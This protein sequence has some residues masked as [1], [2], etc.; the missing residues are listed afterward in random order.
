MLSMKHPHRTSDTLA[1]PLPPPNP[2]NKC[3]FHAAGFVPWNP[4][5]PVS[6]LLFRVP[7]APAPD[8]FGCHDRRSVTF[9]L[10]KFLL[11]LLLLT[12]AATALAADTVERW[13]TY[14]IALRGPA[15]GNP[16]MD[17]HLAAR[18]RLGNHIVD[19]AGFY[20]GDGD[21][22]IR[23]MPGETGQWT[24]ATSSNLPVLDGKT[25]AFTVTAPA[26]GN[27]GPVRVRYA[28][29]FAY[30]DGSPYV[31][32]GTTCYAWIHQ[33]DALEERTLETLRGAPFNKIRMC[34]FP[35][36]YTYNANEPVY[37]PFENRNDFTRFNPKF[38]QHM[39]RRVRDLQALGIEADLILFHPYDRWSYSS[40][41]PDADD[42][43]LRYITARLRLPQRL[44]VARQ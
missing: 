33:G 19:A 18:F 4:G 35:K 3:H 37:Y 34:V 2:N 23:F 39:E 26:R 40:M 27:H 38:F 21:Y 12:G 28:T 9:E 31:P 20:D 36:S 25:G 1:K 5:M 6:R 30:E 44:V 8:Q 22:R 17:I 13:G 41:P 32:I 10:L 7:P 42:R 43:Y 11:P 14:E 29:H 16:F 24:Y 15:T